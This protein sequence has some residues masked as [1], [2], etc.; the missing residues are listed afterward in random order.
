MINAAY[1]L[2]VT[3]IT[4]AVRKMCDPT[5]AMFVK[6]KVWAFEGVRVYANRVGIV[7]YG[8]ERKNNIEKVMES[9]QSILTHIDMLREERVIK[10][11]SNNE[12]ILT[13]ELQIEK[14][15]TTIKKKL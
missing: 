3:R 7:S 14:F 13:K 6:R 10:E 15:R 12:V 9:R 5:E 4:L 2:A 11:R 1:N 8:S